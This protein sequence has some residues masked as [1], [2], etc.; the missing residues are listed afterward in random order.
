M[1]KNGSKVTEADIRIGLRVKYVR[2][3]QNVTQV[4]L[5]DALGVTHQQIQKYESGRNRIAA[6]RLKKIADE[7]NTPIAFF[8]GEDLER[9]EYFRTAWNNLPNSQIKED[10]LQL[11]QSICRLN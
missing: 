8:L 3:D 1:S 4:A 7:L 9:H 5:G 11:I 2:E 6:T 10:F